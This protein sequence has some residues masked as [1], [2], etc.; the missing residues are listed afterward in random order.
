MDG[1]WKRK[2]EGVKESVFVDKRHCE[3]DVGKLKA[4][5]KPGLCFLFNDL[6]DPPLI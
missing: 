1:K 2:E 3:E 5:S 6:S 4:L